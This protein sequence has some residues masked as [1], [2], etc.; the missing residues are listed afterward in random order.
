MYIDEE[1]E[2]RVTNLYLSVNSKPFFKS[3]DAHEVL[4]AGFSSRLIDQRLEQ[5]ELNYTFYIRKNQPQRTID[6]I[7]IDGSY[8]WD[9]LWGPREKAQLQT[10]SPAKQFISA[11]FKQLELDQ[12]YFEKD[13]NQLFFSAAGV[14]MVPFCPRLSYLPANMSPSLFPA[15]NF[16][17]SPE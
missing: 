2:Y 17:Y 7:T 15:P 12:I 9:F 1:Y 8:G 6:G 13:L 5:W 10:T 16:P 14:N 11:P 3:W 4:F